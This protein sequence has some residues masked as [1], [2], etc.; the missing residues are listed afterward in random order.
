MQNHNIQTCILIQL[1]FLRVRRDSKVLRSLCK[2]TAAFLVAFPILKFRKGRSG[3]VVNHFW[4]TLFWESSRAP[5]AQK[6]PWRLKFRMLKCKSQIL[7]GGMISEA[8]WFHLRLSY[9]RSLHAETFLCSGKHSSRFLFTNVTPRK[10]SQDSF[11]L[12]GQNVR[13]PI[14]LIVIKKT[15]NGSVRQREQ[16]SGT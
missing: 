10:G 14:I 5:Q 12:S 11:A 3:L 9:W 2:E 4:R 15:D 1:R 8:R 7:P 13:G 6:L 16:Y